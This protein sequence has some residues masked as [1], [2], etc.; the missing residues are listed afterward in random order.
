MASLK[1][2]AGGKVA[3]DNMRQSRGPGLLILGAVVLTEGE[4]PTSEW[5]GA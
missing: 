1:I 5:A 2:S 4:S 3:C